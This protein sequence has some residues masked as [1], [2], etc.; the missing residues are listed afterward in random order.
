MVDEIPRWKKSRPPFRGLEN[1]AKKWRK[2]IA[3]MDPEN[4]EIQKSRLPEPSWDRVSP[5]TE[6]CSEKYVLLGMAHLS[7][8]WYIQAQ[9]NVLQFC[10]NSPSGSILASIFKQFGILF[11]AKSRAKP[12]KCTFKKTSKIWSIFSSKN[13]SNM[14]SK[15]F[16]FWWFLELL[17]ERVESSA[18]GVAKGCPKVGKWY[19]RLSK[20]VPQE[21]QK[22]KQWRSRCAFS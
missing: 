2:W 8:T 14:R 22:T 3:I 11:R 1:D 16:I 19:P 20:M 4:I 18:Q 10:I 21:C 12:P 13:D 6:K 17:A 7:K 15:K 9:I 5:N